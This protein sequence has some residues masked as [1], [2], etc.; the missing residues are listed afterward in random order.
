MPGFFEA[1][2]NFK[3]TI[4][5]KHTVTIAG[6]TVEVTLG[7]KLQI[8]NTGT[9]V[10]TIQKNVTA[11]ILIR[12]PIVAKEQQQIEL[13]PAEMGTKFYENNP[14]WPMEQGSGGYQWQIK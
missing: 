12:K 13:V 3:N 8:L 7:Q 5:K 4:E 2:G 11:T 14:F 1:L 10:W 9:D 6:E